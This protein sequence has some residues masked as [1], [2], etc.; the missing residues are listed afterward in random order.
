VDVLEAGENK[1][2]VILVLK[3]KFPELGPVDL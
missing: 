2:E 1:Y 3:D